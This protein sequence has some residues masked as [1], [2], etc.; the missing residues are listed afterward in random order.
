MVFGRQKSLG[1]APPA[2]QHAP[3]AHFSALPP[4]IAEDGCE[5][6]PQFF[7]GYRTGVPQTQAPGAGARLVHRHSAPQATQRRAGSIKLLPQPGRA[8]APVDLQ[9]LRSAPACSGAGPRRLSSGS[10]VSSSSTL[11]A[12]QQQQ[13]AHLSHYEPQ[14]S[15]VAANSIASGGHR[16][17]HAH[18]TPDRLSHAAGHSDNRLSVAS[19]PARTRR[20]ASILVAHSGAAVSPAASPRRQLTLHGGASPAAV[21]RSEEHPGSYSC[22]R[23]GSSFLGSSSGSSSSASPAMSV[24]PKEYYWPASMPPPLYASDEVSPAGYRSH[25]PLHRNNTT[26]TVAHNELAADHQCCSVV[27]TSA[28]YVR[29]LSPSRSATFAGAALRHECHHRA[30]VCQSPASPA[31]INAGAIPSGAAAES[32]YALQ[33]S[34]RESSSCTLVAH[35]MSNAATDT[36][37]LS[38]Q[39]PDPTCLASACLVGVQDD[40][41]INVPAVNAIGTQIAYLPPRTA[42]LSIT[43]RAK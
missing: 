22:R 36:C 4:P 5:V 41:D 39:L 18:T 15:P 8:S 19:L 6:V 28:G 37:S 25:Q 13:L 24:T 42:S 1:R 21:L 3:P 26:K 40:V 12:L 16:Q 29:R 33:S 17:M 31:D 32:R 10:S 38:K 14:A 2:A 43:N 11:S 30:Y 34:A 23:R 35:S 9:P 7:P 27:K 20:P